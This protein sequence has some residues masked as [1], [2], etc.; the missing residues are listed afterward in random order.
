MISVTPILKFLHFSR[1]HT[2]AAFLRATFD[3]CFPSAVRVAFGRWAIVRFFFAALTAFFIFFRA[4]ALCFVLGMD[5]LKL[6]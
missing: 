5:H 1:L 3:A 4:A 6:I 2:Y